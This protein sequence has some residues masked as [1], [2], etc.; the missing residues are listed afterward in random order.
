MHFKKMLFIL[1]CLALVLSIAPLS[2]EPTQAQSEEPLY[3]ALVW[4]QHQPVYFKDPETNIYIRPWV[5]VHAAKSYLDMAQLSAQYPDVH[6]TFNITPSL[7]RQIEDF[8]NGAKDLYWVTTEIPA[9]ELTDEDKQFLVDRFFDASNQQIGRFPRYVELQTMRSE[10]S[11]D[12]WTAQDFRDL[13]VLFNLSWTD[14][15]FLAEE[16]LA[17]LVEKERDFTEEDK[18]IILGE[19]A[20]YLQEVLPYHAQLQE[21]GQI[22]VTMTPFAHPILPLLVDSN[23]A[24]IAMP[25]AEL[26]PRYLFGQDAVA[27]VELGVQLYEENYGVAPRGMWPAEGSVSPGIIQM[28]A[29]AGIQWIATDEEILANSLP[30]IEGFTRNSDDTVVQADALY[31]PYTVTGGRGGQ[32]NIIFRDKRI[33]DLIGFEYS[34]MDGQEAADDLLG[35]LENIRTALNSDDNEG[36]N[37]VTILLDG[38]NAWE[39]YENDGVEFLSAMYQGFSDAENIVA[40]T[41]SEY[42][43]LT[44]TDHPQIETLWSGSWIN[45]TYDTWI[46][47]PEENLGWTYLGTMRNDVQRAL[48]NLDEET[49]AQVLELVYL[50]E[51][52][53]WF[54]WY[55]SDQNAGE[56]DAIFDQQFRSYLEQIYLLL[57][58]EVPSYVYVP[59]VPE[60]AQSPTAEF[61]SPFSAEIDGV[62]AD[63]EWATAGVYE[64]DF[65]NL[66]YGFDS[67]NLYLRLDGELPDGTYGLYLRT[68]DPDPAIA[69]ARGTDETLIGFGA[70]RLIEI[71]VADGETEAQLYTSDGEWQT[72]DALENVALGDGVLEIGAPI[73]TVSPAARASNSLNLR[74][75]YTADDGTSIR[76]PEFGP[77]IA[78]L[79]D[80]ELPN[81]VLSVDDPTNDDFGPGSYE[82]PTDAVFRAGA[83]DAA[84]FTVGFDDENVIFRVTMDGPLVND[85]GSPNGM[86]ILTLDVYI[87]TDGADNGTRFLLPGRNAALTPEF[88]WDYAIFAEGWQPAIYV[89]GDEG[90][91]VESNTLTIQT[92]PGQRRITIRVPRGVIPGEPSEWAYAVTV[93][94]Q[95]G[96]PS[97]G[98]L[99]IRDV[100]DAAEQFRLGGGTGDTNATRLIDIVWPADATPTQVELLG[101]YPAS[102]ESVDTLSPDDFPQVPMLPAGE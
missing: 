91:V 18:A 86:G 23:E 60:P 65:A 77:A 67:D 1:F 35:R 74:L 53:D 76:V 55:G 58:D 72:A 82:Y 27:Q 59:I 54:W 64:N 102:Q 87:D 97:S 96:F 57:G 10:M 6:V 62:V 78:T 43:D 46:G 48:R 19:H 63:D 9:E 100:Q 101:N 26:P 66:Y 98:V 34:G 89:P 2:A 71:T 16:P 20:R 79:P 42:F 32:V 95:E 61:L 92:N 70:H 73:A 31:R 75:I 68:P 39:H 21:E 94:S 22:E 44:G 28:I 69:F 99:R 45:P 38:E 41:P 36:P 14:P 37:L 84:N 15:S 49:A 24:A 11:I 12:E 33:S 40:V 5:R 56:G 50:A 7:I 3:V 13:Q 81:V 90:A 52:S 25:E 93:A 51:G 30:D 85:W 4:H 8:N 47:E 80:E 83:Y 29:N 88:A 17:A